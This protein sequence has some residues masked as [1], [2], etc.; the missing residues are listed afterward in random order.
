MVEAT[1]FEPAALC[2]QSRCATKLRYASILLTALLRF[3]VKHY[4]YVYTA[5]VCSC[6]PC[7]AVLTKQ[8][9]KVY[10]IFVLL[11]MFILYLSAF[12][13]LFLPPHILS[14]HKVSLCNIL[15]FFHQVLQI[16]SFSYQV[17][18]SLCR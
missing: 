16:P 10:L 8:Q 18:K 6:Y 13:L 3:Y 9:H 1:G 15:L 14:L 12:L 2:S 17:L 5:S 4:L 11:S 7:V